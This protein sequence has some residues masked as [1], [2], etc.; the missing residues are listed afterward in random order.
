M[1]NVNKEMRPL[2]GYMPLKIPA[3]A[4]GVS[5][6]TFVFNPTVDMLYLSGY[7][8]R[9]FDDKNIF[10]S[11]VVFDM[12]DKIRCIALDGYRELDFSRFTRLELVFVV[13]KAEYSDLVPE[14]GN[15]SC[16]HIVTAEEASKY[17]LCGCGGI[18]SMALR[19]KL[20]Q[21][22]G[23]G[24]NDSMVFRRKLQQK[25]ARS[26]DRVAPHVVFVEERYQRVTYRDTVAGGRLKY[27]S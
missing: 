24:D 1:W 18:D 20:Q 4:R 9:T 26:S 8:D 14:E 19:I 7:T 16:F 5:P 23:C 6:C 11:L 22:C 10:Y 2:Y 3:R 25:W 17:S 13:L 12:L 15:L 21:Q 27:G